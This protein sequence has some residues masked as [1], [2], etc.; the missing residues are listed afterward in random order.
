MRLMYWGA[1]IDRQL[2]E[3]CPD[4]E[5]SKCSYLGGFVILT[6]LLS[7]LAMTYLF[8]RIFGIEEVSALI[9]PMAFALA[10]LGICWFLMVF[11]MSRLIIS[12]SGFG[13]RDSSISLKDITN[14]IIVIITAV[15]LGLC[16]GVSASVA[17][18]DQGISATSLFKE[19]NNTR[20]F[21]EQID[22]QYKNGLNKAYFQ[23]ATVLL[24]ENA[25]G[26]SGSLSPDTIKLM[27]SESDDDIT[28]PLSAIARYKEEISQKKHENLVAANNGLF[29]ALQ[30]IFE[31]DE[32]LVILMMIFG[33]LLHLTPVIVKM[34]WP[35]G[36]YEYLVGYQDRQVL[37][38]HGIIPG[39]F[40]HGK[41]RHDDYCFGNAEKLLQ[42]NIKD[43]NENLAVG[44]SELNGIASESSADIPEEPKAT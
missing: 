1:A 40:W 38:E 27:R 31:R 22:D 41:I 35:K 4:S 34:I 3:R 14:K 17:L 9:S 8:A 42:N 7:C 20:Y 18:L 36:P 26:E 24:E 13:N 28:A 32:G 12:F 33:V 5:K 25:K 11:N 15:V 6:S 39:I 16:L 37:A 21:N 10:A 2:I 43:L 23:M 19:T 30:S 44:L 29:S